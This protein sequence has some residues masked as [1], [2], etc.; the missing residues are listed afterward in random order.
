MN[1]VTTSPANVSVSGGN[2]VLNLSSSTSGSLISTNPNGGASTGYQF[3]T[4][5]VEAR[6]KFPGDGTNLYN[7]PAFW[8]T[9]QSWPANGENDIAEVLS[10]KMT[11]NY[12]SS[13][14]S[15]NQGTVAGDWGNSFH[16]FGLD[17]K[18]TSAD[19]YF[20]GVKVKSY[21]TDDGNAPQYLVLNV[22]ASGSSPAAYGTASQVQVDYVRAWQ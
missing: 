18:A 6:I 4:G 11:V 3:T 17:R 13:S 5:Y 7:W 8:T 22:G 15:H 10:G 16:T 9:G 14:G 12:H 21:A 1:K 2:L 19:V 20:D